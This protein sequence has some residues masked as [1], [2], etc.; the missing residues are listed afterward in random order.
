MA[1]SASAQMLARPTR[2]L[3][4]PTLTVLQTRSDGVSR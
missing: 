3:P 1:M 4:L 2:K